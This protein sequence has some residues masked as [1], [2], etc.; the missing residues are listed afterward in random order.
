MAALRPIVQGEHT[1]TRVLPEGEVLPPDCVSYANLSDVPD[2]AYME[3]DEVEAQGALT[4]AAAAGEATAAGLASTQTAIDALITKINELQ[5]Q[6]NAMNGL[7]PAPIFVS[8]DPATDVAA[9]GQEVVITVTNL[10]AG[11]TATIGGLALVNPVIDL[12]AGT[13][14]GDAPAHAAGTVD[15]V[16]TNPA[17]RETDATT[18]TEEDGFEYT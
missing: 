7:Y 13:I 2:V 15:V 1:P 12:E 10:R 4:V 11:A 17:I 18:D 6:V 16:V 14:T 8:I 5:A 3:A 9:G